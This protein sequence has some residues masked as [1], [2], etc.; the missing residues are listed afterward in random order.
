MKTIAFCGLGLMGMPMAGRL[1]A[2]GHEVRAWDRDPAKTTEL[3]TKGAR[4][5]RSPAA[6]ADGAQVAICMV[7]DHEAVTSVVLGDKGLCSGHP[8]VVVQMSTIT[9]RATLDIRK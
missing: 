3:A 1:V 6:A 2:A 4:P 8:A 7:A 5:A 9:P